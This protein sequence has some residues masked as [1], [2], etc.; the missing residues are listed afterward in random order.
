ME[1]KP[2]WTYQFIQ[3]INQR[4]A[5]HKETGWMASEDGTRYTPDEAAFLKTINFQIPLQVHLIK[6]SFGGTIIT[7]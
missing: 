4:I 5:I 2:G 6:K 3:T 1:E 7:L